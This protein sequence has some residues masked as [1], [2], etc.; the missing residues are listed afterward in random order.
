MM[1][2]IA[3]FVACL[4]VSPAVTVEAFAP[5]PTRVCF[6]AASTASRTIPFRGHAIYQ[7]SSPTRLFLQDDGEEAVV[8]VSEEK[9]VPAAPA[10][11]PQEEGTQFPINLPSPLLLATSMVLAI[12]STGTKPIPVVSAFSCSSQSIHAFTQHKKFLLLFRRYRFSL[13]AVRR[14]GSPWLYSNG[15]HF[16]HWLS[17]VRVSFLCL[18]PQSNG[19][20]GRGRQEIFEWKKEVVV[21]MPRETTGKIFAHRN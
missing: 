21:V 18:Y 14:H 17:L 3:L 20:N 15:H 4:M 5:T 10:K 6:Q 13:S 2:I 11:T 19:G 16:C 9:S 1:R 12:G 7:E 8:A